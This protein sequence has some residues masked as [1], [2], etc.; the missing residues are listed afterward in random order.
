MRLSCALVVV[1]AGCQFHPSAATGPGR[2]DGGARPID[3][4]RIDGPSAMPDAPQA[5]PDAPQPMLDAPPPPPTV[6]QD[7]L[8]WFQHGVTTSGLQMIDPDGAGGNPPFQ[9]YCDM[10]T[11]GGGWTLVW[12][13]GFTDYAHFTNGDNAVTPRPT[14][15]IPASGS[16]TPTSTTVPT[17]PT[18]QGALDFSRWQSLGGNLLVLS[19]ITNSVTCQPGTGSLVTLTKG[20]LTCQ[21]VSV[22]TT[23]CTT[24]VP[25]YIN[26][27][28][29]AGVGLYT[30]SQLLDTYFFWE[31]LTDTGNWPTHDPCGA[32]GAN[33]VTNV[34]S[35]Y[36]AVYL[37]R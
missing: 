14:W 3:A 12:V 36:G 4:R 30:G 8:D 29:P 19:N 37:R 16:V 24:T 6:R 5:T 18:T 9:A 27:S 31:G 22:I 13:Y 10:T 34:P 28:D 23:Q 7:C 21:L 35:P 25:S 15:G 17:G 2:S 20:T 1:G 33:Q 11:A 26:T 32:N